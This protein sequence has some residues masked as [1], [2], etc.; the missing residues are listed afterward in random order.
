MRACGQDGVGLLPY[1]DAWNELA[2]VVVVDDTTDFRVGE[3]LAVGDARRRQVGVM[4]IQ[5]STEDGEEGRG[6][7]DGVVG[8]GG[9]Q[10][11]E[12][13]VVVADG[14]AR[15]ANQLARKE[16]VVLFNGIGDSVA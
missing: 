11:A 4:H 10:R 13:D 16:Q 1:E 3:R 6:V 5:H 12:Q 9:G 15:L 14:L 2:V 8:V 7:V